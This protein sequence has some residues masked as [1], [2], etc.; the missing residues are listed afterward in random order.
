MFLLYLHF[1]TESLRNTYHPEQTRREFYESVV[2]QYLTSEEMDVLRPVL[3]D[4]KNCYP[5][6][7]DLN[8]LLLQQFEILQCEPRSTPSWGT[9]YIYSLK[10]KPN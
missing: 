1:L 2:S 5:N 4:R 8:S 10:C 9:A 6:H 7:K 3:S